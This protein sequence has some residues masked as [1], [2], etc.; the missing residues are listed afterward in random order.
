[1]PVL[2]YLIRNFSPDDLE[3]YVAFFLSINRFLPKGQKRAPQF[4]LKRLEKPGYSPEQHLFL[5]EKKG[6]IAGYADMCP[7]PVIGRVVLDGM[8]SVR[9]RHRG[10]AEEM[11]KSVLDKAEK[12]GFKVAHIC[13][14][15]DNVAARGLLSK[16]GFS[17]IRHFIELEKSIRDIPDGKFDSSSSEI[18]SLKPGDEELL[19]KIQN[20]CFT[21]TWGFCPN[22]V[23]EITYYL[24]LTQS[25]LKDVLVANEEGRLVGYCWIHM[26]GH[27]NQASVQKKGRVHMLG[28]DPDYRKRGLGKKLLTVGLC[29]LKEKGAEAVELTADEGSVDACALYHSLGFRNKSISLWYEKK[30]GGRS[31]KCHPMSCSS[32]GHASYIKK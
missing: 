10:L 3:K 7:E 18:V 20:R 8:I 17:V 25:T 14:S 15:E 11:M 27:W 21:G 19:T 29:Y 24:N 31:P 9:H 26:L 12:L 6:K 23:E 2:Q 30:L 32:E 5:A 1:M 13:V 22:S 4:F 28:V 16:F